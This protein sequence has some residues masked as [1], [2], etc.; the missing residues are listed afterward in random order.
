M[1]IKTHKL[2]LWF[3]I[4]GTADKHTTP[5]LHTIIKAKNVRPFHN[6]NVLTKLVEN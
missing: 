6:K 4:G 1:I 2:Q 5:P 3:K